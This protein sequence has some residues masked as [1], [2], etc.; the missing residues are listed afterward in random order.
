[1]YGRYAVVVILSG[2]GVFQDALGSDLTVESGDVIFVFP[3]VGHRYGPAGKGEWNEVF[4]VF[5]GPFADLLRVTH[6]L[7]P[8]QPV[9]RAGQEWSERFLEFARQLTGTIQ[10]ISNLLRLLVEILP[11]PREA[12]LT[13]VERAKFFAAQDLGNPINAKALEK[14]F[15]LES[16]SFRKRFAKE[17]GTTVSEYRRDRRIHAAKELLRQTLMNHQQIGGSLGFSDEFHFSKSFKRAVGISPRDF[18]KNEST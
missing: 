12:P 10:D 5:E 17:T 3:E 9:V 6:L 14:E 11:L 16:E 15:K 8:E 18:R 4:L 1:M 13:W 2:G 7:R